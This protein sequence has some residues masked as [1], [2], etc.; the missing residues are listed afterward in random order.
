MAHDGK[1]KAISEFVQGVESLKLDMKE[2]AETILKSCPV[3]ILGDETALAAFLEEM[4]F[5]VVQK[6]VITTEKMLKPRVSGMVRRYV[7][8]LTG[9]A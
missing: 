5:A 4:L 6:H 1:I 3:E 7:A 8:G 9:G 2:D